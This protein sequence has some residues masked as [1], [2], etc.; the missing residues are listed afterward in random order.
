MGWLTLF[1]GTTDPLGRHVGDHTLLNGSVSYEWRHENNRTTSI[2]L[3]GSNVFGDQ[4]QE[5][6]DG[7]DYGAI[8]MFGARVSF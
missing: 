6:P 3:E 1:G 5:H 7:N 8:L 2:F 4:H